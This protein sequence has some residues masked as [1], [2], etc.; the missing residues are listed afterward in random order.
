[1]ALFVH[2]RVM[3]TDVGFV[4]FRGL[5]SAGHA[6]QRAWLSTLIVARLSGIAIKLGR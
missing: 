6:T 1:V 3:L 4:K 2:E 5:F